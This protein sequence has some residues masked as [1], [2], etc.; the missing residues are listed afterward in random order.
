MTYTAGRRSVLQFVQTHLSI[1]LFR[2]SY[3]LALSGVGSSA[4]G[5]GF[6]ALA[7]RMY[8]PEEIGRTSAAISMML[9]LAAILQLNLTNGLV[10]FLPEAG[11][12]SGPLVRSAYAIAV[13]S[14]FVGA[15][16]FTVGALGHLFFAEERGSTAAFAVL[17]IVAVP[18][19]SV[20]VLQDS[21]LIGLRSAGTV[22]VGNV[23]FALV[24]IVLLIPLSVLPQMGLLGAWLLS[25]GLVIIPLNGYIFR[26]LIPKHAHVSAT[27]ESWWQM[28][29]Y[30]ASDYLGGLL[31]TTFVG[32]LPVVVTWKLGLVANAYFY[33]SWIIVTGLEAV[34]FSIGS[35]LTAEGVHE[36]SA[37]AVLHHSSLKIAAALILPISVVGFVGAPWLLGIYGHEYAVNVTTLFQLLLLAMPLRA[38]VVLRISVLRIEHRGLSI[39]GYQGVN[40]VM[41]VV[42][43][44]LVLDRFGLTGMGWVFLA[45]QT[46]LASTALASSPRRD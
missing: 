33:T 43:A 1:P 11:S 7:V 8:P 9:L 46:L 37:I 15:G 45:V 14:S 24:K 20:F 22:L 27:V 36:R 19:W 25:A 32:A 3:A 23:V 35:S 6:W 38:V 28:R 10:L 21:V 34:L 2:N 40:A 30:L 16:L 12:R 4:L 44:L 17:F 31:E 41:L 29:R 39:I 13:V 18:L 5:L 26:R 42:G